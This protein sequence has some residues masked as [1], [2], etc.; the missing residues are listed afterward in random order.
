MLK[1]DDRLIDCMECLPGYLY[2]AVLCCAMLLS[3][4]FYFLRCCSGV[5]VAVSAVYCSVDSTPPI[6]FFSY[7]DLHLNSVLPIPLHSPLILS[8]KLLYSTPLSSPDSLPLPSPLLTLFP[9]SLLHSLPL[10]STDSLPLP[11]P[12]LTLFPSPLLF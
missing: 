7:R 6:Y 9:S 3:L 12:L 8:T 11:S 10:S 2:S 4:L 1:V 5:F